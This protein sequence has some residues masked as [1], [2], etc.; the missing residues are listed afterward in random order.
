MLSSLSLPRLRAVV[1]LAGVALCIVG[2]FLPMFTESTPGVPGSAHPVYE[3][4]VVMRLASSSVLVSSLAVLSLLGVLIVLAASVATWFTVCGPRLVLLK[5]LA[6]TWGLAI[7]L[8]LDF[9]VLQ[10]LSMGSAHREIAAGF[11][12]ALLGFLMI[13]GSAV[14]LQTTF[15]PL[16]CVLLAIGSVILGLAWVFF[17][18]FGGMVIIDLSGWLPLFVLLGVVALL[19]TRQWAATALTLP[20][21]IV[22]LYALYYLLLVI[23]AI[24][25]IPAFIK[26]LTAIVILVAL[27]GSVFWLTRRLL[28]VEQRE[29]GSGQLNRRS[30]VG[31]LAKSTVSLAIGG[32]FVKAYLWDDPSK[33]WLLADLFRHD[34]GSH[35]LT[36]A[37]PSGTLLTDA[38]QLN[39]SVVA[40]IRSPKTV[41]EVL[42]AIRDAKSTGKKISL[43][44]VRHSMG[45]QALGLQTLHLDM[46]HMD[47]VRYDDSDQTV[48]VG[49]G[50]TWRQVQT[51]LSPHGRAVMVMQD[52][53]IF[54]VGGSLS[55]NVH[56]KDP[57]YG[58]LIETV[59]YFK[60]V[61][62]DGNEIQCDRTQH[63]DLF[64]A[65]IGG[66]G[67]LGII[68]EVNLQTIPNSAYAFSLTPTP[69]PSLIDML[70][71]LSK[72][73]ANRLLEA[74]LSVDA[75]RFLT[76][77]LIYRYAETSSSALPKD[78]LEGENSIWLRK[79]VFQASRASNVGKYLRWE[80]EKRLTPLVEAKTVSRNTAMAVPVRFLQNPDPQ[81]TDVLQEYFVPTEQANNFL[82]RYKDL[83]RKHGINLLN[84][85]IRKVNEDVSAL[86]SYA[87]RDMYGFVVYYKVSKNALGTQTLNA[88]TG[89]LIDYL[90]S[91]KATYY[92]CYGSYY[93]QSQLTTMYPEIPK[94]F[95]LKARQDPDGLLT[96]LWYEKYRGGLSASPLF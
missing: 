83:I 16:T 55:V 42:A 93:A 60:V 22:A 11:V 44:G 3:W 48:T 52:S 74:H 70:E 72:D 31:L 77:S 88:F 89:E 82:G 21:V 30:F 94:L 8:S 9:M 28:P 7:Q 24:A 18:F 33:Q 76:E 49:P 4:Q 47:F 41:A 75:E 62:M 40:E 29:T 85:T 54:S 78:D 80:L 32:L 37:P 25:F 34:D 45:G 67:L 20:L 43:S 69:T 96:N 17:D 63:Q 15:T 57:H 27:N 38:S 19:M 81:T 50:A 61:T 65:V 12:V 64:S 73:P 23:G 91:I 79:V 59:K 1:S 92:L 13:F 86:V 56:G 10:I 2:F 35:K 26:V 14:R 84:V 5:D 39:S 71:S 68:T 87:Q 58:S 6:A 51:V 36:L 90:I 53:N 95:A 46:T 66:Y